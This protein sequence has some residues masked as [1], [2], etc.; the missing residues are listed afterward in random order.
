[1]TPDDG[2]SHLDRDDRRR[3]GRGRYTRSLA[4]AQRDAEACRLRTLGHTYDQIA[5][6]LGYRN[7][8]LA[9][10]AVQRALYATVAEPAAE[11][12]ALELARL[13]KMTLAAW[14]VLERRHVTVSGGK[15]ITV[16]DDHGVEH[17]LDDDGPVLQAIDRL[18]R[19]QERRA[20]LLGLDAPTRTE[21]ITIDAVEAEI[22]RLTA[23]LGR[24]D[25]PV[26]PT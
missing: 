21:V 17:P 10:R 5:A 24:A 9:W 15:V 6:E 20:R 25:R 8:A 4:T 12:R 19:I 1:M 7:R 14:E 13:D 11:V 3:D 26:E 16:V 2:D 22:E 18:L 23:E